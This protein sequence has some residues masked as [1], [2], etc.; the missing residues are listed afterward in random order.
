MV[1]NCFK[2]RMVTR[3]E[4]TRCSDEL[5]VTGVFEKDQRESL[6][7]SRQLSASKSEDRV[8]TFVDLPMRNDE[9]LVVNPPWSL[10]G[11]YSANGGGIETKADG[12]RGKRETTKESRFSGVRGKKRR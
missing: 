9:G 12:L 11:S 7:G 1:R 2:E 10:K 3:W 8:H 5:F 4:E 6:L